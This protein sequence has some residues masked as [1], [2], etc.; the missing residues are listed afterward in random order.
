M[1]LQDTSFP[2]FYVG[3]LFLNLS[4]AHSFFHKRA[5]HSLRK[6]LDWTRTTLEQTKQDRLDMK[7]ELKQCQLDLSKESRA[8]TEVLNFTK[9]TITEVG[10]CKLHTIIIFIVILNVL[11]ENGKLAILIFCSLTRERLR[12]QCG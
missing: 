3:V 10:K 2:S 12:I 1:V 6:E 11:F 5:L 7:S 9:E 4:I 8:L